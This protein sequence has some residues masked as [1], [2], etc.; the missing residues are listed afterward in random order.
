MRSDVVPVIAAPAGEPNLGELLLRRG[1]ITSEHLAQAFIAQWA[2]DEAAGAPWL[3]AGSPPASATMQLQ[4]LAPMLEVT[5]ADVARGY[6]DAPAP[7]RISVAT[8]SRDGYQIDLLPR[9]DIFTAF[10]VHVD[11]GSAELGQDGGTLV[12][13]A[14]P[15]RRHEAELTF[16]F[17]LAIGTAPGSYRFPLHILVRPL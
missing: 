15:Q 4:N 2:A 7:T 9:A 14:G 8:T 6:V 17:V 10:T 12:Q 16:R 1:E 3:R 13:R 5:H 11:G